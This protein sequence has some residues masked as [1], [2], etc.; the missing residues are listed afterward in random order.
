[1]RDIILH[2]LILSTFFL[3]GTVYFLLIFHFTYGHKAGSVFGNFIVFNFFAGGAGI[4]LF[5][6]SALTLSTLSG[7]DKTAI[8]AALQ[9]SIYLFL[10]IIGR[11]WFSGFIRSSI[12]MLR[13]IPIALLLLTILLSAFWS[14]TPD[15]TFRLSLVIVIASA[16]S[17]HIAQ[18]Y[19]WTE[20]AERL[21]WVILIIAIISMI[22]AVVA[23]ST[24]IIGKGLSGLLPFPIRFGTFMALGVTLWADHMIKNRKQWLSCTVIIS[25]QIALLILSNSAQAYITALVMVSILFICHCLTRFS[26]RYLMVILPVYAMTTLISTYVVNEQL[27]AILAFFGKDPGLTGRTEFW[28]QLLARLSNRWIL[29]YGVN[30]FWQPWRGESNPANSI[31]N[32][33]GFIPPHAHNGFLDLALNLGMVGLI[34]FV[35]ALLGSLRQTLMS[36]LSSSNLDFVIPLIFLT[37]VIVANISET[38]LLG[39]GYI[40]YL[41]IFTSVRLRVEAKTQN[42]SNPLRHGDLTYKA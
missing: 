4:W 22:L 3:V 25:L 36:L 15:L 13:N 19:S 21:R 18:K 27:P 30:G 10:I 20:I 16:L 8:S 35:L 12:F 6:Y 42:S 39:D 34:L 29:G 11:R 28:G 33:N 24:V 40:W 9:L 14:E 37:Y 1:M 5:P 38:Q 17:A 7:H 2:P 31:I 26:F 32:A 41:F 23:P